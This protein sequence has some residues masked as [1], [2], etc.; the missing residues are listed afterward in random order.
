LCFAWASAKDGAIRT[1]SQ[2]LLR[3]LDSFDSFAEQFSEHEP[4]LKGYADFKQVLLSFSE[5]GCEGCRGGNCMYPGC[6]VWPC[7][8]AKGDDFCFECEAFPCEKVGL[9]S[10]LGVKWLRANER[11]K[12]IGVEA[13]FNESKA[14]SHYA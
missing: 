1:H 7:I 5:A 10:P 4:R 11:M 6:S 8:Q 13:Y 12:E 2:A 14:T 3:L 9:D